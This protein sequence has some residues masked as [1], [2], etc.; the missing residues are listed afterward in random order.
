MRQSVWQNYRV[1]K[2]FFFLN[3]KK[4]LCLSF[5]KSLKTI[6]KIWLITLL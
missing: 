3:F 4:F 5:Y 6:A 2:I 1:E